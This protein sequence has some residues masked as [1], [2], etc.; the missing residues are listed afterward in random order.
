MRVAVLQGNI[1]QDDKWNPALRDIIF[2]RYLSMTRQASERGASFV[3]W[4]ESSTPFNFEEDPLRAAMM[5]RL[6]RELT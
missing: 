2:G 5:R 3:I 1:A 4:P 6:A